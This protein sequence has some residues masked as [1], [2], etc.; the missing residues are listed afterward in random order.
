[1]HITN[2]ND[3]AMKKTIIC[4]LA[5]AAVAG[6]FLSCKKDDGG[7]QKDPANGGVTVAEANLVAYLP[8]S[9]ETEAVKIGEGITFASASG[10]ATFGTGAR[11]KAYVNSGA[12]K[13]SKAFM[14]FNLAA[15]NP[16]KSMT[17]FTISCW[18]KCPGWKEGEG[19][20]ADFFYLNGG[21][22][23][24]GNLNIMV[25][26]GSDADSL[27]MKAYLFNST[28]EWK[29]QDVRIKNKGF[30][31]DKWF[32]FG[33]SYDAATSAM[34]LWA[35]GQM[36]LENIRY[37]G[38]EVGGNQPLLGNLNLKPDMTKLY[39]GAWKKLAETPDAADGWMGY[40]PGALDELRIYNKALSESEMQ[41]LYQAEIA[42]LD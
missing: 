13:A 17:S 10:S 32:L 14:T 22:D 25:E 16:F 41:A 42:L 4:L 11:G 2:L 6:G 1:M 34:R 35:N 28:T 7:K 26:G 36:V 24:M 15:A 31:A 3:K 29:G 37:G 30:L 19:C 5:A 39:I 38:P 40:Y 18:M 20:A 23:L 27:D 8:F 12:N 33:Y 9:S 21:D